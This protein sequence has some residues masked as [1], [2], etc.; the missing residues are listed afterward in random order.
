MTRL[1]GVLPSVFRKQGAL[2]TTNY[3]D[4]ATE[5][6]RAKQQPWRLHLEHYT[7]FRLL[8]DLSG[9]SVIDL[10]CGEGFYTRFIKRRGA[11]RVVGVDLSPGMIALAHQEEERNRLGIDYLVHDVKQLALDETFD[12]V[13]AAYLLNY[14][15]TYR[16][17]LAMCMAITRHLKPGCRFVTV[18]NNPRH[19]AK[20]FTATR[21]YGFV[22]RA[23]GPLRE[24]T[25]VDYIFFLDDESF[26]ITNYHLTVAT[27]EMALQT[28][29]FRQ[30]RW[31][32]PELS[33]EI[34]GVTERQ[35]WAEFLAHP[36]VV[37]I[38]CVK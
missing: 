30:V 12:V 31:H 5:Y 37:C 17:L 26:A 32:E 21:P 7:L 34:V 11:A 13:V 24:G 18:N 20:Y 3:D 2:M 6:Q 16:E 38:D 28:A 10:A 4:I 33:P 36:P 15:Q 23:H 29:G 8:G 25:P 22:K 27:H 35:Y 9:K 19:A 14:A 1:I